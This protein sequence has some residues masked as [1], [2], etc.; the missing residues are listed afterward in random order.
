M[1]IPIP[2]LTPEDIKRFNSKVSMAAEDN[3]WEWM[4]AKNSDGRGLFRLQKR[5]YK[6]SRII[7]FLNTGIDPGEKCVCHSC[8]NPSC[9]NPRHLWLGTPA[10]NTRDRDTKGRQFTHLGED[11]GNSILTEDQ[12]RYILLSIERGRVLAERFDISE[13]TVSAIRHGRLWKYLRSAT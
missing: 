6:A 4:A 8:D 9:C 7:Y 2:V 3:C 1:N 10:E 13:S 12:A 11:H 5:L